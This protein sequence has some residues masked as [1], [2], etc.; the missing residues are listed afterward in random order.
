MANVIKNHTLFPTIISEFEYIANENLLNAIRAEELYSPSNN[1]SGRSVNSNLQ[2][3]KEF[4]SLVNKILNTTKE[5]CE[6][7]EYE[8]KS[9]EITGLWINI[10][11]DR[12]FHS[13]HT[14]SNNIFSGVWYPIECKEKSIMFLDPRPQ[15]DQ[16]TPKKRKTNDYTTNLV[17]FP[18]KRNLGL[19]FP[20]WLMHY[21][22][23]AAGNRV[24]MSW[25]ILIRG[26][27]GQPDTLQN[28][29]I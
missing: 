20:S 3:K 15:S 5:I 1:L 6:L 14:H 11:K 24:S 16:W 26:N 22:P 7:Y 25:N 17:S 29:S 9:I 10:A 4:E 8:Y 12:D 21:V 2:K 28:A 27:Y 18:N 23:P 13:P 19:I